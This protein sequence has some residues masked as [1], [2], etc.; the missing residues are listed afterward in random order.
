M[1]VERVEVDHAEG[2][3]VS[4]SLHPCRSKSRPVGTEEMVGGGAANT[5]RKDGSTP[6]G[7]S[8]RAL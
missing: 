7:S 2:T 3:E 8:R 4:T 6:A 5:E 1:I